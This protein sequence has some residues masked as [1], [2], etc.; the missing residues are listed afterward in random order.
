M[1]LNPE[2]SHKIIP[3]LLATPRTRRLEGL[4]QHPEEAVP[5][6]NKREQ[7]KSRYCYTD[8]R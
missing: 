8:Q 7:Q 4:L 3:M 1:T 6:D 2:I 5:D